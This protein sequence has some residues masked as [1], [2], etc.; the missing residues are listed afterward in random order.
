VDPELYRAELG[1][2][3]SI[4]NLLPPPLAVNENC[5]NFLLITFSVYEKIATSYSATN[6]LR[7]FLNVSSLL[8]ESYIITR[9]VCEISI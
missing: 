7:I 5:G 1:S 4:L 2:A 6:V 3:T 9:K 8:H